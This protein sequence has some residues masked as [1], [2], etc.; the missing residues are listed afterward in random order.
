MI[1]VGAKYHSIQLHFGKQEVSRFSI[2]LASLFIKRPK[3]PVGGKNAT[4]SVLGIL[5][6]NRAADESATIEPDVRPMSRYGQHLAVSCARGDAVL[7][8]LGVHGAS[9]LKIDVEGHE[10][11]VLRGL[12]S[13][14]A[15]AR[16]PVFFEAL[17]W[18]H[19]ADDDYPR[20]YY[21]ELDP[22]ARD[23]IMQFSDQSPDGKSRSFTRRG[24]ASGVN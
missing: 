1:F 23:A 7:E 3:R 10:P 9:L 13:F 24:S 12:E 4:L 15:R 11:A 19:L 16:P 17:A 2:S 8:A 18:R 22:A 6:E 21:G 5:H 20:E 14:M